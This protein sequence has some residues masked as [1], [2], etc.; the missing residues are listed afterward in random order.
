MSRYARAGT[1]EY[2]CQ[3]PEETPGLLA[4]IKR[5]GFRRALTRS[6]A[7]LQKEGLAPLTR[8]LLII[9]GA[10]ALLTLLHL[11]PSQASEIKAPPCSERPAILRSFSALQVRSSRLTLPGTLCDSRVLQLR[12]PV[13]KPP[14]GPT[15][16]GAEFRSRRSRRRQTSLGGGGSQSQSQS[17]SLPASP[18][19]SRGT[20]LRRDF[21][22]PTKLPMT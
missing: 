8:R 20:R 2:L 10:F 3:Q 1:R 18:L 15:R 6:S 13:K 17:Q 5:R 21:S 4:A 22:G 11:P 12:L 9:L 19:D 7:L 16:P 14:R